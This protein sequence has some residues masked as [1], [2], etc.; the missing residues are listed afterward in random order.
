MRLE[1]VV[2]FKRV[3]MKNGHL[4]NSK[5]IQKIWSEIESDQSIVLRSNERSA[6][7]NQSV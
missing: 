5:P 4:S 3:E 6:A 2:E 1:K 7:Q